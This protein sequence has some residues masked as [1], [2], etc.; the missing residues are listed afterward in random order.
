[1]LGVKAIYYSIFDLI[2]ITQ[3]V[4]FIKAQDSREI[5]N[6]RDVAISRARLY[7]VLPLTTK[8]LAVE[9]TRQGGRP[10]FD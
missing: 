5:I 2:G 3:D 7:N 9:K 10:K 1:M 8:K 6:A 4:S